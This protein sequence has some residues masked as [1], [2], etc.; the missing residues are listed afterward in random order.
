VGRR[1][2]V[3]NAIVD[4]NVRIPEGYEIGVNP[5][6]DEATF[7]ISDTGIVAVAKNQKIEP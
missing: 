5:E 7:T 3:R 2:V 6:V 1:A 4:K